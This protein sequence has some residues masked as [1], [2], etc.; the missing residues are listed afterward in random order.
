MILEI[1]LNET[2]TLL[3]SYKVMFVFLPKPWEGLS[4][5]TRVPRVLFTASSFEVYPGW[6]TS[7]SI[8]VWSQA[9]LLTRPYLFKVSC[10]VMFHQL[11][12]LLEVCIGHGPS[13]HVGWGEH[14]VVLHQELMEPVGVAGLWQRWHFMATTQPRRKSWRYDKKCLWCQLGFRCPVST[15][16]C[17]KSTAHCV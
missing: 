2:R 6:F 13:H 5:S 16:L 1:I 10:K 15:A 4:C 8:V 9:S 7:N 17:F 14:P 12:H 11:E 3:K